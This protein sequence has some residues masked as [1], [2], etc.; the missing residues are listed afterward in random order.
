[1]LSHKFFIGRTIGFTVLLI[2]AV[3]A[4]GLYYLNNWIYE[5][6]QGDTLPRAS[7]KDIA[8]V[9][10]GETVELV[11]GFAEMESAP[12]AASKTIIRYFGNEAEGDLNGDGISDIAF[13]ITQEG[14]GSGGFFYAVGAIWGDM[15]YTGSEAVFIGDRI[16]PQTAEVRDG[17]LII[18]YADRAPGEPM[19]TPPSVDKSLYLKLDPQ[20]LQ[21]GEV[22]QNFEGEAD[23]AR[24]TLTM[25][26]W[27]WVRTAY[28]D[29]TV[30]TP[31]TPGVFTLTF[32]DD[33]TFSAATDCN[34]MSGG[35][36][37]ADGAISFGPIAATKKYCEGSQ[38]AEFAK[39][40][41]DTA[42]YH[43]T[44]K[45]ELILDLK[46]DNGSVIFR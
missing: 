36:T 9:I 45:G 33:S 4:G 2:I 44:S 19:T 38:E 20:T 8:Y 43:F 40:L 37:A 5:Q 39:I 41:S 17:L 28:S 21:F 22:V 26:P 42:T 12:G 30:A 18:N 24:M 7:Y 14:G 27:N 23:P 15:G 29:G 46:F 16:A 34:S 1:M 31:A 32:S 35:Y 10:Q 6:K 3:I 13:L 11:G 25:K